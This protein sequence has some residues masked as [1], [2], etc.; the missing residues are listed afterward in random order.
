MVVY[1]EYNMQL[2][3]LYKNSQTVKKS[4]WL[5]KPEWQPRNG[6][7]NSSWKNN[8]N[9]GELNSGVKYQWNLEEGIK[10]HLNCFY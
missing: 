9:S 8:D 10:I 1:Y 4:V 5:K 7:I 6:V 2:W 3:H